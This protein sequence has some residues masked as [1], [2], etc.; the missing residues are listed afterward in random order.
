MSEN[1]RD[2]MERWARW[3]LGGGR[4]APGKTILQR[5]LDGMPSTICPQC[6][7]AGHTAR[8]PICPSCGGGGRVK[9]KP[10]PPSVRTVPCPGKCERGEIDG[11]TCHRCGGVGTVAMA[12]LKVN[13]AFIPSTYIAPSDPLS[14]KIDRL[15][16]ELRQRD[17]LLGHWFV[18]YAEY[19]DQRKGTQEMRAQRM[20]LGYDAYKKRL[21]RALDWIGD[22]LPDPRPCKVIPY[23]YNKDRAR[24]GITA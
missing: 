20:R 4:M 7:G 12:E 24:E 21:Q 15:V 23:P 6:K 14:E 1:I 2:Y 19:I 13:P 3:R 17:E 18:V 5:M 10:A 16:C 8:F 11:R 22:A 9:L